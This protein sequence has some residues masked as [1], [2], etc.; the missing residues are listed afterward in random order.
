[1][2]IKPMPGISPVFVTGLQPESIASLPEVRRLTDG[3]DFSAMLHDLVVAGHDR[4]RGMTERD[5]APAMLTFLRGA[6]ASYEWRG[7][8]E[9]RGEAFVPVA[10]SSAPLLPLDV[11]CKDGLMHVGPPAVIAVMRSK[12][13]RSSRVDHIARILAHHNATLAFTE[14]DSMPNRYAVSIQVVGVDRDF[15]Q[16]MAAVE[17]RDGEESD[18][19]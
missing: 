18:H 1:M 12:A 15:V 19:G 16:M 14:M 10:D 5:A 11:F 2:A 4:F 13:A 17:R 9:F 8:W 3:E 7:R 6:A